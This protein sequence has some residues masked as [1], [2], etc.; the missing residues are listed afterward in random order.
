MLHFIHLLTP[1]HPRASS[2]MTRGFHTQLDGGPE[3]KREVFIRI[4]VLKE[5]KN[6]S[7]GQ[8]I[9]YQT[10]VDFCHSWLPNST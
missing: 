9:S 3:T 4:W 8:E 5:E 6:L 2:A 10:T 1:P 7:E